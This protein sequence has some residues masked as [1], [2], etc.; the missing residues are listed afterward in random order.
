MLCHLTALGG[1][2]SFPG[3]NVIGPLIVWQLKKAEFP[4]VDEHGKES[5]NFQLSVLIYVLITSVLIGVTI[6]FCVGWVFVPVL[7]VLHY[8]AVVF[9]VIGAIKANEGVFYRYPFN[10]RLIK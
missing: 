1:L 9:G 6:W 7:V 8:G 2:L 3:S 10:L 4:S 5:F